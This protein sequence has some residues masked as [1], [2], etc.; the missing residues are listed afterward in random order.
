MARRQAERRRA[1]AARLAR[2]R[3]AQRAARRRTLLMRLGVGGGA[4][5]LVA[6]VA[7]VALAGGDDGSS[8]S[9]G[10]EGSAAGETIADVHGLGVN[11]ADGAL[12]I[13]THTGLFRSARGT[14]TAVR[15]D[16]PEQDLMGFSVAGPDRFVA[17][18]HPG[19]DQQ[20]P[21]SLG[22]LESRDQGRS[23][24]TLSLSGEADFH[25]LRASGDAVYAYDGALRASR[26]GG[27]TWQQRQAPGQLIDVAIDPRDPDRVLAST[28]A[29]VRLS[30]DGGQTWRPTSL[31][32]PVLLA[33]AP[34]GRPFAIDA[35]GTIRAGRASGSA[36]KRA[37][38]WQGQPAAFAADAGGAL[39]LAQGDGS[40]D[41]SSDGGRT[42]RPRSRN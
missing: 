37:G 1:R 29:G 17:S 10:S 11:P 8:G 5:A 27:R 34:A 7:V 12:Y 33:W 28:G 14:A 24:E 35:N 18:G 2:E 32:V 21:P 23:W 9:P 3:E 13:A 22:L 31:R 4:I 38:T 19:P 41:V 25:V 20:A 40:V 6:V 30:E 42:W 26:D 39:Y 15:V 16:A 36:W